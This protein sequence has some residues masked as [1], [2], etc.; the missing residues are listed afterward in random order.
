L[1]RRVKKKQKQ[2]MSDSLTNA[3]NED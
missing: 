3:V 2:V 1:H